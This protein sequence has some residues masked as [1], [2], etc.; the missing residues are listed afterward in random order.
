MNVGIDIVENKRLLNRNKRFIDLVLTEKEKIEYQK[1]GIIYLCGRFSA[2]EAVMKALSNT[3]E[4]NFL[5]IEILT[6]KDGSPY[7][8]NLKNI[9]LSISHEKKYTIAI[10]IVYDN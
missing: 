1:R 5:D 7:C 8:S 9:K 3:K 4:L 6:N 2:K 10:A